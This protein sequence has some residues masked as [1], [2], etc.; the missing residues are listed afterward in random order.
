MSVSQRMFGS[1]W[2]VVVV[3]DSIG[4]KTAVVGQVQYDGEMTAATVPEILSKTCLLVVLGRTG[5]IWPASGMIAKCYLLLLMM[6]IK[7]SFA[8][9][10]VSQEEMHDPDSPDDIK[11]EIVYAS[12]CVWIFN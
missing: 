9:R 3:H 10:N 2:N 5:A 7:L 1:L 11:L 8:H 12:S 4:D 6:V